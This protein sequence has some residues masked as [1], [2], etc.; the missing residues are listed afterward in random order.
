MLLGQKWLLPVQIQQ[1]FQKTGLAHVL[2]ISGLHI[3]FI[4]VVLNRMVQLLRLSKKQSFVFITGVLGLYC[5]LVGSAPSV[6]RAAVMAVMVLGS[7]V[8]G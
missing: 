3:G 1:D 6:I 4:A 2:A 8:V 5:V 7:R